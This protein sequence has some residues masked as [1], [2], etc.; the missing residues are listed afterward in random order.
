MQEIARKIQA[1]RDAGFTD[2]QIFPFLEQAYPEQVKTSLDK[3]FSK[4]EILSF[5]GGEIIDDKTGAGWKERF[6]IGSAASDEDR[7][8]RTRAFYGDTARMEKDGRLTFI[9][10]ETG[11][12]TYV[13][14]SGFDMGDVMGAGR[15]VASVVAGIP[16]GIAGAVGGGGVNLVTGAL[17]GSAG[18]AAAGQGVDALA[19]YLA[20]SAAEK[21]GNTVPEMQTPEEALKEAAVETALGTAG[22]TVLGAAGRGLAKMANPMKEHIVNAFKANGMRIPT[23]ATGTGSPTLIKAENAIGDMIGGGAVGEAKDKAA[24]ELQEALNSRSKEIIAN[25]SE[26][27]PDGTVVYGGEVA[28]LGADELGAYVRGANDRA[29]KE[30]QEGNR[31]WYRG[32]YK[33]N[34]NNPARLDNAKAAINDMVSQL[35]PTVKAAN[36]AKLRGL[37]ANELADEARREAV[38]KP[39]TSRAMQVFSAEPYTPTQEIGTAF[40]P[41]TTMFGPWPNVASDSAERLAKEPYV[42][43]NT[44][45]LGKAYTRI[46]DAADS[47]NGVT[48]LSVPDGEARRL[49][50]AIKEDI[51][52]SLPFEASEKLKMHNEW[53]KGIYDARKLLKNKLVSNERSNKQIGEV[54]LSNELP[55]EVL[56]AVDTAFSPIPSAVIRGGI[57]RNMGRGAASEGLPEGAASPVQ[58]ARKLAKNGKGA[59]SEKVQKSL[60]GEKNLEAM[61]IVSEALAKAVRNRNTSGTSAATQAIDMAKKLGGVAVGAGLGGLPGVIGGLIAPRTIAKLTTSPKVIDY[62]AKPQSKA[63]KLILNKAAP[64]VGRESG[65]SLLDMVAEKDKKKSKNK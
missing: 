4:G 29:F 18:G 6:S 49:A 14:P 35:S 5:L 54:L 22:G 32:F 46:M 15:D 53:E 24:I 39:V 21:Q 63:S 9:H 44:R 34:G 11:K 42:G 65:R 1:S 60:I 62:L 64:V 13:N 36:K 58:V 12:R 26:V 43:L 23:V 30:F 47:P 55:S 50:H 38:D 40:P 10:P 59:L 45:T 31:Q 52:E 28:P 7:L 19:A 25:S 8:A 56:D 2:E 41:S 48:T 27:L 37:I 51:H 16:A 61:R 33:E 20:R 57:V 3:G 17:A